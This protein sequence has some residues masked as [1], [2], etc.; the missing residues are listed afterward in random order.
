VAEK[1]RQWSESQ[2]RID[3]GKVVFVDETWS[4]T[5][6]TRRYGR[7]PLGTRLVEKTPWGHWRT[8]TFLGGLRSTG[9]VAR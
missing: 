5:N 3:P 2:A 9:F 1:R 8:T 6:M 4:K 7:S